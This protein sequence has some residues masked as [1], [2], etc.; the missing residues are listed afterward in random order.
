M[1]EKLQ[2]LQELNDLKNKLAM[3]EAI[4]MAAQ[5]TYDFLPM[6]ARV[7]PAAIVAAAVVLALA[8]GA[9]TYLQIQVNNAEVKSMQANN[10]RDKATLEHQAA[11]DRKCQTHSKLQ[12]EKQT[13]S[14][15]TNQWK[16]QIDVK[17]GAQQQVVNRTNQKHNDLNRQ[18][19]QAKQQQVNQTNVVNQAKV[20][21]Q[22]QTAVVEQLRRQ[23]HD[24]QTNQNEMQQ[25]LANTEDTLKDLQA[26][27][28]T[29]LEIK[30]RLSI[31]DQDISLA[32]KT[33]A[34]LENEKH[35]QE[36]RLEMEQKKKDQH[37]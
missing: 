32:T 4:Q 25:T 9:V 5:L 34:E 26:K 12:E 21:V 37:D 6:I 7:H 23:V 14:T 1:R 36:K 13:L 29:A 15:K 11:S 2:A 10:Q 17:R 8:T 35:T 3:A 20:Q 19:M 22:N 33:K 28:R 24:L 27:Q 16:Q 31:V 18:L 30:N